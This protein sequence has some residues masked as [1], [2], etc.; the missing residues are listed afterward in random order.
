MKHLRPSSAETALRHA[1]GG[2]ADTCAW[3]SSC[4]QGRDRVWA[5]SGPMAAVPVAIA[6]P[7]TTVWSSTRDPQR[8]RV[9][10]DPLPTEPGHHRPDVPTSAPRPP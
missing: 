8:T 4:W 10:C 9:R 3:L 5:V 7:T 2:A 1:C 6:W